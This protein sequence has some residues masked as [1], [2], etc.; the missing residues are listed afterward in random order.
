MFQSDP[1]EEG[2]YTR[3]QFLMRNKV[4]P[5]KVMPLNYSEKKIINDRIEIFYYLKFF[6][7]S[8]FN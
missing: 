6:L 7:I 5:E 4:K 3:N 2:N 1:S 8:S